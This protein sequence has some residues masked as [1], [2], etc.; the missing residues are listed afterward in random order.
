MY[1]L[2]A[3]AEAPSRST[4]TI[5]LS[6]GTIS[7]PL[8]VFTGSEETR[9]PRKEFFK[10]DPDQSIGRKAYNKATGEDVELGDITKM[11]Q[12]TNG[13]WVLLDDDEIAACALPKGVAE[14][15][16]FVP[17]H[18]LGDYLPEDVAQVRPPRTKGKA[19]PA[20]VAAFSLFL[21]G[22]L[23]KDVCALIK[24]SLRGPARYGLLTPN[25]DLVY[26]K[27]ADQIRKSV[28]LDKVPVDPKMVDLMGSL[29][30]A[31]G[32]GAPAIVNDTAAAVQQYVDAK[33]GGAPAPSLPS[34]PNPSDDLMASLMASVEAAKAARS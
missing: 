25:G 34:M 1:A 26:V 7:I 17:R 12:A 24:L 29:I 16:S 3:K 8:S 9:V 19:N 4:G 18:S 27:T 22:L 30:E 20:T 10:G 2:N 5:T 32:I 14:V 28:E 13:A 33:A 11:A 21:E 23:S 31:V 6:C 15:V